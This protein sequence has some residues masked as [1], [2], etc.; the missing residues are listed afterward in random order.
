M[1]KIGLLFF[2]CLG[3]APLVSAAPCVPGTLATYAAL[4]P[5]GCTIGNNL[6]ANF[7]QGSPLGGTVNIPA[8]LSVGILRRPADRRFQL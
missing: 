5:G 8:S 4:G 7:T 1:K 3:A 6:L 2:A